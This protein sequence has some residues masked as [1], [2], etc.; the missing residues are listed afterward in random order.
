M[1]S[2]ADVEGIRVKL[3]QERL[4]KLLR[5][6]PETGIFTRAH[7]DT[8]CPNLSARWLGKSAGGV[9]H[10]G[11]VMVHVAGVRT[12]AHRLAWLYMT[13]LWPALDID[14]IN[15]VRT[16]NRWA[17][18]REVTRQANLQNQRKASK[19]NVCGLL[20]VSPKRGKFQARIMVDRKQRRLGV[21]DTPEEAHAAY[22]AAKRRLHA[23]AVLK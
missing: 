7:I 1:G 15:G 6:D 19:N 22:L 9:S 3:T 20:G 17:N 11:Y 16:D 8:T 21:F 10:N 5:Y 14:H 12:Q 18:L 4:K 23:G 2:G 13:G